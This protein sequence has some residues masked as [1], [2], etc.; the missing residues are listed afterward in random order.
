MDYLNE[1]IYLRYRLSEDDLNKMSETELKNIILNKDEK[2]LHKQIFAQY[3]NKSIKKETT[4]QPLIKSIKKETIHQ[5]VV[6]NLKKE[7]MQQS[8]DIVTGQQEEN[9]EIIS[10]GSNSL[11]SKNS[12]RPVNITINVA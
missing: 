6:E 2:L 1:M 5:P 3:D 7:T 4:E 12:D 10:S 11:R 8:N 9:Q